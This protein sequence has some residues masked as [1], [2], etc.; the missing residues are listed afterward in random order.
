MEIW[1]YLSLLLRLYQVYLKVSIS[2][3]LV[4]YYLFFNIFLTYKHIFHNYETVM[5]AGVFK[6]TLLDLII[7][8]TGSQHYVLGW[9]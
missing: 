6:D 5:F 8:H 7:Q 2:T 9:M 4:F 3:L 1:F